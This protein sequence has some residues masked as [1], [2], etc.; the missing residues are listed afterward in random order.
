MGAFDHI[1]HF[2]SLT[3]LLH[4]YLFIKLLLLG[5]LNNNSTTYLFIYTISLPPGLDF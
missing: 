1:R 3:T 2:F 4:G 5:Q